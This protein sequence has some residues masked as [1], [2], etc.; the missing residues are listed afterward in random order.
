MT[1]LSGSITPFHAVEVMAKTLQRAGFEQLDQ[2]DAV[3]MTPG[4]GY[5]V[6]H[7]GSSLMVVQATVALRQGYAWWELI[8]IALI[9]PLSLTP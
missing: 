2:F 4:K 5:F 3:R 6:V 1:F 7:Q 8:R 9:C